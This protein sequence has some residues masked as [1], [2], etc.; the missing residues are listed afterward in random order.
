M[1]PHTFTNTT[2]AN[3]FR[4]TK[5]RA[6]VLLLHSKGKRNFGVGSFPP[7]LEWPY[8]LFGPGPYAESCR[9]NGIGIEYMSRLIYSIA[10]RTDQT[11]A[12]SVDNQI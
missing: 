12:L 6:E 1:G 3:P 5:A 10:H 11:A 4:Y 2:I 8:I 7:L 9:V